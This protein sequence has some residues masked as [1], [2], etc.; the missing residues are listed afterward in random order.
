MYLRLIV[1][2]LLGAAVLPVS[3][4]VVVTDFFDRKIELNEPAERI[5]ALAP[6]IVENVY[7]AGV[8]KHLVGAVAHSDYPDA[9][10]KL[11]RVGTYAN[12]N[13][14]AVV[15]LN[16]DLVI[17]WASEPGTARN[18][19]HILQRMGIPVYIANPQ[20]L[21][22]IAEGIVD[23]GKLGG[24]PKH[25]QQVAQAYLARLTELKQRYSNRA[26]VT[27]FY[28]VWNEP[29]ITLSGAEFVGAV[30]RLCGGRNVFAELSAVA[31]KISL[32]S[33]LARDP[34]AIV[35]SGRDGVF[36]GWL[37]A[38]KQW[39]KLDAVANGHLFY[40][41]PDILHRPTT[42]ILKGAQRLCR[43]LQTVR[44][45]RYQEEDDSS[46]QPSMPMR[47][48]SGS[49]SAQPSSASMGRS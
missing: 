25:A 12:I 2:C 17:A 29:L 41:P 43:Q 14:E 49:L 13:M 33:V 37:S 1:F 44:G 31:P 24:R 46:G 7:K 36:Q 16:P 40:V 32:E 23:Y 27:V 5:V 35:T 48:S 15:A 11:P 22:D 3:A 19:I 10:K 38:W 6:H 30:I 47:S 18:K 34:Q 42:R 39:S 21:K 45:D 20:T 26:P 28:Q 8:G 4:K 9:A